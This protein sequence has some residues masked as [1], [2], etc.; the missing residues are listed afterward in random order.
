[1]TATTYAVSPNSES[2]TARDLQA[3]A[4][5]PLQFVV[6]GF[7]VEGLTIIA[8]KPK[9]GKSWMVLDWGLAVACGG[10]A[11]GSVRCEYGDVLYCALED[12]KRRLQR[13]LQ[14]LLGNNEWPG[15][16]ELRTRMP[17]L[18][19]GALTEIRQWAKR[20]ERPRLV[21]IDTF[22]QVKPPRLRQD[23][24]YDSDYDALAPLQELAGDLGIAIV[25]IHH[26]RKQE[27]EDPL[28]TVSGGPHRCRRHRHGARQGQPGHH[29]LR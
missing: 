19:D 28:D 15:R 7:V 13:R 27:S 24:A 4:F 5:P 9:I 8:G 2:F 14:Q 10:I 1:M 25:V 21:V 18:D 29:G 11:F 3:M 20:A 23:G 12:N 17:R 16:L 22:K 26:T 6:P